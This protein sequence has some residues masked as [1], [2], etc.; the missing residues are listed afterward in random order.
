MSPYIRKVQYYETDMMG[1]VHH[2]NYFRWFE[3]GRIAYLREAGIDLNRLMEDGFMVPIVDASCRYHR[4]ARFDDEIVIETKLSACSK[5]RIVFTY[6]VRRKSDGVILAEGSTTNAF[7]TPD[8][9]VER[10]NDQY[11]P[12]LQAKL[13][14]E[15]KTTV[16]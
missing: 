6:A 13:E 11:Y 3:M 14:E 9:K 5:V 4:P 7:T 12:K 1:V 10:L 8:G 16:C 2:A 15:R